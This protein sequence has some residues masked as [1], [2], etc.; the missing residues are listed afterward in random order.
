MS[1]RFSRRTLGAVAHFISEAGTDAE[2]RNFFTRF[3]LSQ[4]YGR[5]PHGHAKLRRVQ[6]VLD[7]LDRTQGVETQDEIVADAIE[8]FGPRVNRGLPRLT[9][10]YAEVEGALRSDGYAIVDGQLHLIPASST[11]L[12]EQSGLLES[13][14]QDLGWDVALNHL[15]QAWASAARGHWEAANAS[16]RASLQEVFD[17][18][19]ESHPDYPER[20]LDP[21]GRRRK[22]LE[23]VG[24]FSNNQARLILSL[25]SIL[26]GEG[27]HPGMANQ[28]ETMFRE[29]MVT[30][31]A[32]YFVKK[33]RDMRRAEG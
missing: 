23:E 25:F 10:I 4:V 20:G 27:A 18:I 11:S 6:E 26:H 1:K 21:G 22:F 5:L 14:L 30:S 29:G 13:E 17:R 15:N 3:G 9:A 19:A 28:A 24:F 2:L 33:C 16:L 8:R 7:Y 32:Y 31:V 12:R